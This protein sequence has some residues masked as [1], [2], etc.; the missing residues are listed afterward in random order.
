M[1]ANA[2]VGY[3]LPNDE[4]FVHLFACSATALSNFNAP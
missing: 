1:T 4:V 3:M 2:C